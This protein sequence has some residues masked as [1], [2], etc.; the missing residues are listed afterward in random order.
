VAGGTVAKIGLISIGTSDEA[1]REGLDN[2]SQRG[3]F[4]D[5]MRIRAF[6]FA[7][8]VE[9]FI[10]EH[11]TVFVLDQNRDGQL[12]SMLAVELGVARNNMRSLLHYDGMP[13]TATWVEEKIPERLESRSPREQRVTKPGGRQ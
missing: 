6:P 13:L 4:V 7:K 1:V 12:A 9:G 2:L 10:A 11:E 5:D 8:E 3:I